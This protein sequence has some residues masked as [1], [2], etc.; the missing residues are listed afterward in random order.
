MQELLSY[1]RK[2]TSD[3]LI[4]PSTDTQINISSVSPQ[5]QPSCLFFV[6]LLVYLSAF[7]TESL[8]GLELTN[9]LD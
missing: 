5:S 1:M 4:D 2:E 6:V 9:G 8:V 3:L 7:E